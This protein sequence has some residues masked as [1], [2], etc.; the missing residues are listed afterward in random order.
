MGQ[1]GQQREA[2][3]Q[4]NEKRKQFQEASP[5]SSGSKRAAVGVGVL[6]AALVAFLLLGNGGDGTDGS[7]RSAANATDAVRVAASSA[8]QVRLALADLSD[9]R[10]KFYD[11]A[12]PG[13]GPIR[14]FVLKGGDGAYRAALDACEI[15]YHAK[16][17][18]YQNGEE[19]VC[20]K[21]GNS[22]PPA[23]IDEAP[24]GCHPMALPRRVD[25]DHLVINASDIERV[26][27]YL[28]SQ[29]PPQPA[30]SGL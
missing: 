14:F 21:C 4:R 26:N 30:R 22:Y 20:R 1:T 11:Y 16:K 17:G 8:G 13:G 25:G 24:G 19:M 28:A 2:A 9:G 15:C 27:A 3:G 7:Q 18:Y 6:V 29:P 10:A 12:G 23:L 5:K